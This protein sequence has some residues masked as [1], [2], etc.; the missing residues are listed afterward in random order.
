MS[1]SGGA[2]PLATAVDLGR[3]IPRTTIRS[4]P[5]VTTGRRCTFLGAV[6]LVL[7]AP[8]AAELTMPVEATLVEMFVGRTVMW[9]GVRVDDRRERVLRG[10]EMMT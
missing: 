2:A 1:S 6:E 5:V 10:S 7:E 9:P 3:P 4:A 8:R